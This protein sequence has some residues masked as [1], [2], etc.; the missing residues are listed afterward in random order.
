MQLKLNGKLY[1]I[2]EPLV[3]GILNI[4]P[5]S[6]F[7]GGKYYSKDHALEQVELMLNEGA[8]IIDV[9]AFSSRPGTK[10]ISQEEELNRLIPVLEDVRTAFP[11]TILSV[12][13]FRSEV[14]KL[15]VETYN[16]N[17]INDISA[18]EFDSEMFNV[19]AQLNIPY[20]MMHMKGTPEN[21]QDDTFYENVF[22]EMVLFFSKRIEKLRLLGMSDIIIDPGF[23]FGKSIETNY[24]LL[25]RLGEFKI[26]ELPIMVGLSRKSMIYKNIDSTQELS[27]NATT[28]ANMLAL[29]K[30]ANI[31]RVH[32]VKEAKECIKIFSK[33]HA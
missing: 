17:I 29:T 11:D 21:M 25:A 9:G 8:D 10:L 7:D 24:E 22:K 16:V 5:D 3:M 18:G 33:T 14:A 31:L 20:I 6:F 12:D 26:F 32:D 15:V 27:L 4:T 2:N 23:G 19:I 28:A 1:L 30:G 13:T